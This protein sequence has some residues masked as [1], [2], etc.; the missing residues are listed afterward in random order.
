[1][2][3]VNILKLLPAELLKSQQIRPNFATISK[4]LI[5]SPSNGFRPSICSICQ[6]VNL[7]IPANAFISPNLFLNLGFI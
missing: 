1:M 6:F 3:I 2:Y 4:F 7:S 5:A